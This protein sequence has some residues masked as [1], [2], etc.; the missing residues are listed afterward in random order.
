MPS[1]TGS[2]AVC[3]LDTGEEVVEERGD[4]YSVRAW[5]QSRTARTAAQEEALGVR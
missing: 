1:G 5:L 2:G 4:A 3:G